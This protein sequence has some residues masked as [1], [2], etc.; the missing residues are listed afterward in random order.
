[1]TT[2]AAMVNGGI[3][4]FVKAVSLEL[5]NGL[6]INVVSSGL[7]EDSAETYKDYFPGQKPV[8]MAKVIDAY[9]RS[10]EG[11]ATGEIIRVYD[12]S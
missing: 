9:V 11:K 3:H 7:V 5:I 8:T 4:S 6:R 10:V 2:S 12:D 1:M